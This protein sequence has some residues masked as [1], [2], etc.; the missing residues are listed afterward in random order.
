MPRS[1]IELAEAAAPCSLTSLL[2][3]NNLWK[4]N[5]SP[6]Q[7][8]FYSTR[9]WISFIFGLIETYKNRTSSAVAKPA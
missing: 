2:R 6:C 4:S 3:R 5:T 8:I 7:T 1:T 9:R